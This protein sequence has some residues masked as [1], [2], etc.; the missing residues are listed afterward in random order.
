MSSSFSRITKFQLKFDRY[1]CPHF[2]YYS[3]AMRLRAYE[4]FLAPYKTVR[5]DMMAS[6]FGVSRDFVDRELHK[7][8]A[9]GRL[10]CRIDAVNGVIEMNH[11]DSKNHLYKQLIK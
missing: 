2:N 9:A 3:R 5:M 6:D 4:Q 11:P 10:N 1:L 7:F 8:V